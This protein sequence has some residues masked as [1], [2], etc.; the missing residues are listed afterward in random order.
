MIEIS[1]VGMPKA[2]ISCQSF[3]CKGL[4]IN[5]DGKKAKY[6]S[7]SKLNKSAFAV[8]VCNNYKQEPDVEV[9]V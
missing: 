2:C 9:N 3:T 5:E 1:K 7:C 6:G 4:A 8:E